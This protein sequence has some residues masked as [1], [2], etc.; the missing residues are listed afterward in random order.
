M[1]PSWPFKNGEERMASSLNIY[2]GVATILDE[3]AA[4]TP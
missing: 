3:F 2:A 4:Y 1:A